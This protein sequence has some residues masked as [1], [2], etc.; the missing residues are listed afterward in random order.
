MPDVKTEENTVIKTTTT[1][2][3]TQTLVERENVNGDDTKTES[4]K[5][6]NFFHNFYKTFI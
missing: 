3:E 5:V 6:H 4:T 1:E 2:P